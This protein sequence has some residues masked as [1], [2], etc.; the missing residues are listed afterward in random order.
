MFNTKIKSREH[1]KEDRSTHDV[2]YWAM[3]EAHTMAPAIALFQLINSNNEL[4]MANFGRIPIFLLAL[5]RIAVSC[6]VG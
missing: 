5:L 3:C 2:P 4:H 6:L 1:G